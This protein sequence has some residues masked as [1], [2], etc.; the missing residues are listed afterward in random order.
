MLRPHE[1]PE[2]G[3]WYWD[4]EHK[5]RF[6]VVATDDSGNIE[7]Q[8]FGGEVEEL[9]EDAWYNMRLV[10]IAAPKDW[11]GPFEVDKEIFTDLKG[12]VDHPNDELSNPINSLD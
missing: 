3:E 11:S 9:D 5:N 1:K 8:Y 6:E 2:V 12:E 4:I 10:S 7:I